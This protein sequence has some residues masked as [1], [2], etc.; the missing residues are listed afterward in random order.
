M[1]KE[2]DTSLEIVTLKSHKFEKMPLIEAL[3]KITIV[4][5]TNIKEKEKDKIAPK[6]LKVKKVKKKMSKPEDESDLE[7]GLIKQYLQLILNN[8]CPFLEIRCN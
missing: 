4:I 1:K 8:I 3:E 7:V 6:S 5:L 2:P